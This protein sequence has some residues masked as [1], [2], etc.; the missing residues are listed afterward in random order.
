MYPIFPP[1]LADNMQMTVLWRQP[2]GIWKSLELRSDFTT[3]S[4]VLWDHSQPSPCPP[5][6]SPET[7][8]SREPKAPASYGLQSR[9]SI[10][11]GL[12]C[13]GSIPEPAPARSSGFNGTKST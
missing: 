1:E 9:A 6:Q 4:M 3:E 5:K 8:G 12:S 11:D 10:Y 7:G 13:W 2:D